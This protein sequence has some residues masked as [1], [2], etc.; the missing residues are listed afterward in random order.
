MASTEVNLPFFSPL[1][2]SHHSDWTDYTLLMPVCA[3]GNIGQL[4][5]DLIISTLLSR[6]ECQLVGRIYSPS[7]M[8]VVGPNAFARDGENALPTTST[9]VY[10]SVK[11]KLVIMQQRS[12]YY[13]NT[14]QVYVRELTDWI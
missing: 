2:C 6:Q 3:V 11:H 9:E 10:E 4:T 8:P 7:V 13:K 1:D 5:C 14:K 12:S